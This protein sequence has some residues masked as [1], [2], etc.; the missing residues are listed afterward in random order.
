MQRF[1]SQIL[2]SEIG[3]GTV[4]TAVSFLI[5]VPLL[6]LILQ[7]C[8]FCYTIAVFQYATRQAAQY[9]TTHGTN[10]V[11]CQGPGTGANNQGCDATAAATK[12]VVTSLVAAGTG[13]SLSAGSV[14]VTWPNGSNAAGQPISVAVNGYQYKP[15][16]NISWM[17][18]FVPQ[19]K[20]NAS[21]TGYV[22]F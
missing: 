8:M 4:E 18:S 16:Y 12:S 17:N 9:A 2:R 3:Q 19:A 22:L 14:V 6:V 15:I 21:A 20:I 7:F 13:Q 1:G 10:A 5:S 11:G